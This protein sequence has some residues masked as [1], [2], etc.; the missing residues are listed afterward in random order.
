MTLADHRI[1]RS[2]VGSTSK[3]TNLIVRPTRV[4]P[5]AQGDG[6]DT[7]GCGQSEPAAPRWC[8]VADGVAK[9]W[10]SLG[11]LSFYPGVGLSF[12]ELGKALCRFAA[13]HAIGRRGPRYLKYE[14]G[15][16][17]GERAQPVASG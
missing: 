8:R 11:R 10:L 6:A 3:V 9:L 15:A 7:A 1:P 14:F 13:D 2:L 4:A 16:A 17:R 12:T 5:V